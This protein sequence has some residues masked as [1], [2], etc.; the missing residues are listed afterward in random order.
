[1]PFRLKNCLYIN[2]IN[3]KTLTIWSHLIDLVILIEWFDRG[4]GSSNFYSYFMINWKMKF[5]KMNF[6]F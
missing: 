2:K 5:Q 1:M 6:V 3:Q 4:G